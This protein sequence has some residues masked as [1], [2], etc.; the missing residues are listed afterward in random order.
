MA[1]F[2]LAKFEINSQPDMIPLS[3]SHEMAPPK[4]QFPSTNLIFFKTT[5]EV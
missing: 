3:P 5:F 4:K 1:F 2:P